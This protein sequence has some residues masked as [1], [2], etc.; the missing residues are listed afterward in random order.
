MVVEAEEAAR[1]LSPINSLP[2]AWHA[3]RGSRPGP[4][5]PTEEEAAEATEGGVVAATAAAAV[6]TP[7]RVKSHPRPKLVPNRL[8]DRSDSRKVSLEH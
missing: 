2:S 5:G 8:R 6:E 4:T 1:L 7:R 3:R